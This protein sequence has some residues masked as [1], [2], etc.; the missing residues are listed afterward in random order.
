MNDVTLIPDPLNSDV[1]Y[2]RFNHLDIPDLEDTE[3]MD[4]LNC[5]R[6][7]LWRLSSDHWLRERVKVLEG[8]LKKRKW[9][10]RSKSKMARGMS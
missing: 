10:T 4:E 9:N 1:E 7:H 5:L 8:E 6:V 3:L 2:T